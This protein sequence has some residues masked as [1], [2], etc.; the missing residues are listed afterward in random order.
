MRLLQE[1]GIPVSRI[2]PSL[3]RNF[4]RAKGL[5]AKTDNPILRDY[6]ANQVALGKPNK[7]ALTAVMR[8]LLVHLNVQMKSDLE[9]QEE[10]NV[11]AL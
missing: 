9:Q 8:K 5:L 10:A 11:A 1:A 2:T 4:A 3:A 6:D 7:L